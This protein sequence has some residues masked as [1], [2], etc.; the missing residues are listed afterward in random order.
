[1]SKFVKQYPGV[2]S[3]GK[4]AVDEFIRNNRAILERGP[5]DVNL[6]KN[7]CIPDDYPG[8]AG[9]LTL[10]EDFCDYQINKYDPDNRVYTDKEYAISLGYEGRPVYF[11]VGM[12]YTIKPF[13]IP[14]RDY[15][16]PCN[17]SHTNTLIKPF[18]EGDTVYC[19]V[20]E[21]SFIDITPEEGSDIRSVALICKGSA[22]NQKGEKCMTYVYN[23]VEHLKI[24][25]DR[26]EAANI[27]KAWDA[28]KWWSREDHYYSDEDWELIK[29]IW[30]KEVHRGE[31]PLYWED[32]QI[33]DMPAW[34]LEGPIDET[35]DSIP[36]NGLGIGGTR[37]LK[38]EILDPETLKTMVRNPKD[39][40]Y[41][42]KSRMDSF[43]MPPEWA[44]YVRPDAVF[45]IPNEDPL[46]EPP[47]RF[48][49][50]NFLGR[51]MVF[52]HI[53]NWFG[54][55]AEIR[56][57]KWSIMSPESLKNHGWEMDVPVHPD[58]VAHHLE[59]EPIKDRPV[60]TH[61]LERDVAIFKSYVCDKYI[62]DGNFFVKLGWWIEALTGEVWQ[63]GV[64][65]IKLPSRNGNC[66]NR[67]MGI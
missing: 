41:R 2:Y 26:N 54:D 42:L 7:D 45:G 19:F 29:D 37:T 39:G 17:I 14:A 59:I 28:P 22:Y 56:E 46:S 27:E 25:E 50:I 32:V 53:H 55:H 24:L 34:T 52:R 6:I 30:R 67:D 58:Y 35:V 40:I 61:G 4:D 60:N 18:Y 49:F 1:M 13:P 44:I 47:H 43:P 8:Y 15:F 23:L 64:A 11:T 20:D 5:V 51:D 48:H 57:I 63:E 31:E 9:K 10:K 36:G 21:N 62:K 3:M 33:G 66:Q 12:F 16:T 65:E 38:K